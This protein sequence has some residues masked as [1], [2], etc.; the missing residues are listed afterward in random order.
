M[1]CVDLKKTKQGS[2][3]INSK[4]GDVLGKEFEIEKK[5]EIEPSRSLDE[6]RE[7]ADGAPTS[8]EDPPESPSQPSLDSKQDEIKVKKTLDPNFYCILLLII[9]LIIIQ[10]EEILESLSDLSSIIT[11]DQANQLQRKEKPCSCDSCKDR[12]YILLK[13]FFNIIYEYIIN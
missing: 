8:E 6:V 7:E 3:N 12:R 5:E 10:Q 9:N 2:T 11:I 13:L 4:M 1:N